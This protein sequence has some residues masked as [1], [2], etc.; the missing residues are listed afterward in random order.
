MS[1]DHGPPAAVLT[2]A[3]SLLGDPD[4]PEDAAGFLAAYVAGWR[5][6][7]WLSLCALAPDHGQPPVARSWRAGE[8]AALHREE[9]TAWIAARNRE[10]QGIYFT[11]NPLNREVNSKARDSDVAAVVALHA[12]VDPVCEPGGDFAAARAT[13]WRAVDAAVAAG[14]IVPT[15]TVDS[16]NGAGLFFG[17]AEPVA[18]D[19]GRAACRAMQQQARG[20]LGSAAKV[21]ATHDPARLMRLPGTHNWPSA[22]KM[23][24]GV[25]AEG[26]PA[27]LRGSMDGPRL[28]PAVVDALAAHVPV[29]ADP[30]SVPQ[31]RHRA[32]SA[33]RLVALVRD[34]PNPLS[35]EHDTWVRV[36][37][38]IR[39][40]ATGVVDDD[41]E[42]IARQ[43][44]ERWQGGAHD[45]AA[46]A[47]AWRSVAGASLVGWRDM[48]QAAEAWGSPLARIEGDAARLTASYA[49]FGPILPPAGTAAQ[50]AD[51]RGRRFRLLTMEDCAAGRSARR[52]VVKGGL[53]RGDLGIVFGQ[54]GAG[55]SVLAPYLAHG[56]A[57]GRSVF[58]RR[59]RQCPVLYVA[60][61]DGHGMRD[62][63]RALRQDAGDAPVFLLAESVNL[64]RPAD[65]TELRDRIVECGAGVVIVDT[66]AA[67]FPGIK[68][69][70]SDG[71]GQ[72]VTV[73][74]SLGQPTGAAVV[75]VHHGTKAG[76]HGPRG[77][78]LLNGAADV[79]LEVAVV[80]GTSTRSVVFGKNRNGPAADLAWYF[81]V[82]EVLVGLDEDGEPET[83][84]LA[85]EVPSAPRRAP[86]LPKSARMALAALHEV[87]RAKGAPLPKGD[88]FPG[89][90]LQGVT[91]GDWQ[92]ECGRRGLSG[93]DT[94]QDRAKAFRRARA[95][96]Q[97]AGL[98]GMRDDLVWAE[99]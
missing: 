33:E 46:F 28:G 57:T 22:G 66:L 72:A 34:M 20:V 60:A 98:I 78:G 99:P 97:E 42:D 25:P 14:N 12:D 65:A 89:G 59:V 16:G 63:L 17:L 58:D 1:A 84:P 30:R 9:I 96:L 71:M 67:A 10:R 45:E 31:A 95:A 44:S 32:P 73:L 27:L 39:A 82:K 24:R 83:A 38:M 69:N 87:L 85:F 8:V 4:P 29:H 61:E 90:E 3:F 53:A 7:W 19:R 92:A 76:D 64:T 35:A 37:R 47:K 93:A 70:E 50:A 88:G 11:T 26:A 43:W 54:P 23:A 68:E 2:R 40:A 77:H 56:I 18:A 81:A 21:D 41:G 74:R 49:D 62:R 52:Y 75:V 79:T 80:P 86:K 15:F 55:K 48:V 36:L 5:P 51:G 6:E 94:P 13:L 91:A